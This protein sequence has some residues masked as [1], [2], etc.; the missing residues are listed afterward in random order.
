MVQVW[1]QVHEELVWKVWI[2]SG[3]SYVEIYELEQENTIKE[4]VVHSDSKFG[5]ILLKNMM[6]RRV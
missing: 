4:M 5:P 3:F 1:E 2:V 6:E